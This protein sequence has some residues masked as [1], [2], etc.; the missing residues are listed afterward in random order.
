MLD[1]LIQ[2]YEK[3]LNNSSDRLRVDFA[4]I[5]DKKDLE[6]LLK[7]DKIYEFAMHFRKD[8]IATKHKGFIRGLR[9]SDYISVGDKVSREGNIEGLVGEGLYVL[10]L[11]TYDNHEYV[12][13]KRII[14]IY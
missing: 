12:Y 7:I 8:Y 2:K 10:R 3:I 1:L 6:K 4:I 5:V 11:D 9:Y 14:Y 13:K